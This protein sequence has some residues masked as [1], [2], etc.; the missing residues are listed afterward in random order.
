MTVTDQDNTIPQNIMFHRLVDLIRSILGRPMD[1][2]LRLEVEA[3]AVQ[4][5]QLG[6][7]RLGF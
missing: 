7:T 5:A 3:E 6:R 1:F 4:P 2:D